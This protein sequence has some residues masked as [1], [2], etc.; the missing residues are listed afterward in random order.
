MA[1]Y[2]FFLPFQVLPLSSKFAAAEHKHRFWK[3]PGLD[4]RPV[5]LARTRQVLFSEIILFAKNLKMGNV[6]K[7]VK[8]KAE[9]RHLRSTRVF[10]GKRGSGY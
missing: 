2:K 1:G 8:E 3:I 6:G 7:L 9:I 10:T 4:E 5:C